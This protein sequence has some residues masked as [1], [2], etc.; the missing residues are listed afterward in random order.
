MA[1]NQILLLIYFL[2]YLLTYLKLVAEVTELRSAPVRP[3]TYCGTSSDSFDH[4]GLAF[5]M[6]SCSS[7]RHDSANAPTR[8]RNIDTSG[9]LVVA[10]VPRDALYQLKSSQLLHNCMINCI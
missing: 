10:D 3:S 2:T 4:L 7:R 5:L 8:L 9:G 1:L 6:I